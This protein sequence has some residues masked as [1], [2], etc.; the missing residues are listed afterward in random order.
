MTNAHTD[1]VLPPWNSGTVAVVFCAAAFGV[2]PHSA[3][4]F[5]SGRRE[6]SV[7]CVAF[8]VFGEGGRHF[9]LCS[10]IHI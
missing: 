2:L 9:A 10:S 1:H 3:L 6:W 8:C 4:I 5:A 7:I